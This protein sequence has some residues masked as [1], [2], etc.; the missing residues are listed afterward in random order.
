VPLFPGKCRRVFVFY[1][2]LSGVTFGLNN[3]GGILFRN[4]FVAE[5]FG[6]VLPSAFCVCAAC[7]FFLYELFR[8]KKDWL[9]PFLAGLACL[10]VLL[11]IEGVFYVLARWLAKR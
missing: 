3:L 7:A 2:S 11:T 1:F 8:N 10:A 9:S 5:N 6:Y 4:Y